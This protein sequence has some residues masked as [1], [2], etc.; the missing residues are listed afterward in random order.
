VTV[1]GLTPGSGDIGGGNAVVVAGTGLAATA[2]VNVGSVHNVAFRVNSDTSVTVTAMPP[3]LHVGSVALSLFDGSSNSLGAWTYNYVDTAGVPA[4]RGRW[5][6]T[7]HARQFANAT[8]QQTIIAELDSARNRQLA[9]AWNTPA[10]LTFDV[11]GHAADALL[12]QE[13]AHDVVAWRWDGKTNQDVPMFRGIVDAAADVID[14]QSHTVTF[15]CHD[16]AAMLMR[17]LITSPTGATYTNAD[18]DTIAQS[19][20]ATATQP[21]R[22]DGTLFGAAGY[23]PLQAVLVNGDGTG[24]GALSGQLRTLALQGNSVI[25]TELDNL[26]KLANGFDYDVAPF[27]IGSGFVVAPNQVDSLRIFYSGTTLAPQGVIRTNPVLAYGTNLATVQRQ[28][29]SADYGNYWRTLGNNQSAS[30]SASQAGAFGEA[31]NPDA[32]NLTVG[33]WMSP[34]QNADQTNATLLANVAAGKL[35]IFGVLEPVYTLGLVPGF[36]SYGIFNM[37]DTVPLVI[38]SGRLAIN[39]T[40]RILGITYHIGDDGD[41]DVELT[42]GRAQTTLVDMMNAISAD[43]RELSRR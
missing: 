11:D 20:V 4:G 23:L 25:G 43:V 24:R 16:Y 13:L 3:A 22:S 30:Q 14:E 2:Q 37:G 1:T 39:T 40:Q 8:W 31:W 32:T 26:A 6:L 28:V 41:E 12:I 38:N 5:R 9:Q 15:T 35:N 19:L 36:Y 29:A 17:R 10:T 18:Q 7:L 34:D 21:A 33:T 27:G 42:V